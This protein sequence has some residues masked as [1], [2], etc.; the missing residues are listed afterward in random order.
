MKYLLDTNILSELRKPKPHGGVLAWF[1]AFNSAGFAIPVLSLF[2]MQ[3][4]VE[5]LRS[6]DS[7]RAAAFEFWIS[8]LEAADNVLSFD[9]SAAREAA[10][11]LYGKP[12]HLLADGMIAAIAR[13]HGLTI[14]T[15]NTRDFEQ[16]DVPLV[17]PFEYRG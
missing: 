13:V 6:K 9:G 8:R 7:Y 10:R 2:E 12:G 15:R 11:L 16:F 1:T 4:G 3:I 5:Q 14:A 17:N